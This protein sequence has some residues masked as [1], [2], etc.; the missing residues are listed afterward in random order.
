M[1]EFAR[2]LIINSSQTFS[3]SIDP[4]CQPRENA[5]S[6]MNDLKSKNVSDQ[7]RKKAFIITLCA[8]SKREIEGYP[9]LFWK[10]Y[11]KMSPILAF[12]IVRPPTI[13]ATK[14]SDERNSS[15]GI[16]LVTKQP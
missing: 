9:A 16:R 15:E 6:H 1:H 4:M 2:Q 14:A 7:K 8:M 13:H 12:R 11:V 10:E 3:D 5:Y